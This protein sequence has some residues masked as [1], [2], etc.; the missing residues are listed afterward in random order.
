MTTGVYNNSHAGLYILKLEGNLYS[1]KELGKLERNIAEILEISD[2]KICNL[3]I[4]DLQFLRRG[5]QK[6]SFPFSYAFRSLSLFQ[7]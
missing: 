7:S 1:E 3:Q 6:S 5:F 4:C 2:L